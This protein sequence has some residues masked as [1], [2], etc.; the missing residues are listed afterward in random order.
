MKRLLLSVIV[1]LLMSN[2]YLFASYSFL[3]NKGQIRDKDGKIRSE[4]LFT[5]EANNYTIY[6]RK[7]GWSYVI[8]SYDSTGFEAVR[9][10]VELQNSK[11]SFK[12]ETKYRLPGY[13]NF[14]MSGSEFIS[15]VYSYQEVVYEGIYEGIDLRFYYDEG[16]LRYDYI[17]HPEADPKKI[18]ME[19]IHS[20]NP[21]LN[22]DMKLIIPTLLGD[23]NKEAPFTYQIIDNRKEEINSNYVL[24]GNI[25]SFETGDYDNSKELIIDP[26]TLVSA[27]LN[28]IKSL[29]RFDR[30][31]YDP[32]YYSFSL[33]YNNVKRL[34]DNSMFLVTN[35][36]RDS[37]FIEDAKFRTKKHIRHSARYT[38]FLPAVI[39]K[40]NPEGEKEWSTYIYE[41]YNFVISWDATDSIAAIYSQS[42]TYYDSTSFFYDREAVFV[43]MFDMKSGLLLN[44]FELEKPD[45][46]KQFKHT[47]MDGE[48][49]FNMVSDVNNNYNEFI[50]RNNQFE[51]NINKSY[52]KVLY[53]KDST[54]S[55]I[56][57]GQYQ[58]NN[59]TVYDYGLFLQKYNLSGELIYNHE[60]K[61]NKIYL[62]ANRRQV[63][64]SKSDFGC[65]SITMDYKTVCF[66]NDG[67][68][69]TMNQEIKNKEK[70]K[71]NQSFYDVYYNIYDSDGKLIFTS[72]QDN[73]FRFL[74]EKYGGRDSLR[75]GY[76]WYHPYTIYH[77]DSSKN[78]YLT[79]NLGKNDILWKKYKDRIKVNPYNP[80]PDKGQPC[81]MK[82]D[83]TGKLLWLSQFLKFP[84]N[85]TISNL[86][87]TSGSSYTRFNENG[88]LESYFD[89]FLREQIQ[90]PYLE[91]NDNIHHNTTVHFN[92]TMNTGTEL[93]MSLDSIGNIFIQ[94]FIDSME[95][96]SHP[97]SR[98]LVVTKM[99][100]D[101][102]VIWQ[103]TAA[104][105]IKY[106]NLHEK[107][108]KFQLFEIKSSRIFNHELY[109]DYFVSNVDE[110]TYM[111]DSSKYALDDFYPIE[112]YT[113]ILPDWNT[114]DPKLSTNALYDLIT[115]RFKL[116][117]SKL[118]SVTPTKIQISDTICVNHETLFKVEVSNEWHSQMEFEP[119][120]LTGEGYRIV[121]NE[122]FTLQAGEKKE[123]TIIFA[124][125]QHKTHTGSVVFKQNSISDFSHTVEFSGV[126]KAVI[127]ETDLVWDLG[128]ILINNTASGI[129]RIY[130]NGDVASWI[131]AIKDLPA[132]F[133][134]ISPEQTSNFIKG[135][136][137]LDYTIEFTPTVAGTFEYKYKIYAGTGCPD[138]LEV[139]IK[140]KGVTESIVINADSLDYGYLYFCENKT[141]TITIENVTNLP[142][143]Y[144]SSQIIGLNAD[145]FTILEKPND[146]EILIRGNPAKFVIEY[147]P[148]APYGNKSAILEI[149]TSEKTLNCPLKGEYAE[150]DISVN[151]IVM[152]IRNLNVLYD[153]VLTI[154]NNTRDNFTLNNIIIGDNRVT[155]AT[156]LPIE[157]PSMQEIE[158]ELELSS[159]ITGEINT[160]IEFIFS[161]RCSPDLTSNLVCKFDSSKAEI[162]GIDFGK[163]PWCEELIDSLRIYNTGNSPV[164]VTGFSF[165]ENDGSFEFVD[166]LT[167]PIELVSGKYI[168]VAVRYLPQDKVKSQNFAKVR[169]KLMID[170]SERNFDVEIIGERV[171]PELEYLTVIDF[172]KLKPGEIKNINF[173]I[174]NRSEE[175][176]IS[177][178]KTLTSN[179]SILSFTKAISKNEKGL[180][181]ISFSSEIIGEYADEMTVYFRLGDCE[182]SIK[183]ALKAD[184]SRLMTIWAN[185]HT[186]E[187]G[188]KGY[189][190]PIFADTDIGAQISGKKYKLNLRYLPELYYN[191]SSPD[192]QIL[193]KTPDGNYESMVIENTFPEITSTETVLFHLKGDVL[194]SPRMTTP[195][196]IEF[197]ESEA[198]LSITTRDGS[199]TLDSLCQVPIRGIQQFAPTR[200]SVSPN[201]SG[202]ELKVNIGTQED[203]SFRLVIFD[204][205]G[206]EVYRTEFTKS[207][208][209]FEQ[210]DY[211]INTQNLGNGIYT[212]HLTAPWTLLREQVVVVR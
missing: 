138:T 155:L 73:D 202:G 196:H 13:D 112:S 209:T 90:Y 203:G 70:F 39:Y 158:I 201:P 50:L 94:R 8:K 132:P 42:Y 2:S 36:V 51:W 114:I 156:A 124:P 83:S 183:I 106:D 182:D 62:V 149:I 186:S 141:D 56:A 29:Y 77:I 191:V 187:V 31:P 200:M 74:F 188:I 163:V 34:S 76:G 210:K 120:H 87:A 116:D 185:H 71:Q 102:D 194:F 171:I 59:D 11:V 148:L 110:M 198:S 159:S 157:I 146:G 172:G 98:R 55:L 173:E 35:D 67:S 199:L 144:N 189:E 101:G 207:D 97:T 84:D 45:G 93:I 41:K 26:V 79:K 135:G 103:D 164:Q 206:R 60:I 113:H 143:T 86:R 145:N 142:L 169:A 147:K 12:T 99:S 9:V 54:I 166:V 108:R 115:F 66:L 192:A 52:E 49:F 193:S 104:L 85:Y 96:R 127:I 46:I 10:D 150:I 205:Q 23:I 121:P 24:N 6:L 167:L 30:F 130:N 17:V 107:T 175:I 190:I 197:I 118:V 178:V 82:F 126:T 204:V 78:I 64:F 48:L 44:R 153:T 125:K 136:E 38:D 3:E 69:L 40:Y 151:D 161:G 180:I 140:G 174:L 72:E 100:P 33:N 95:Y 5:G 14:I 61:R 81:L 27:K 177:E 211:N 32:I 179:F 137:Y 154:R 53:L 4:V 195:I 22:D 131:Q 184:V 208:K 152:G 160:D 7:S 63:D 165:I 21:K 123:F 170:G 212:I 28:R 176:E 117:D 139:I 43:S 91:M 133:K 119:P 57:L 111:Q 19:I 80:N 20:D 75:E 134:Q 89:L 128:T 37:E 18:S 25:L 105:Y 65:S 109:L 181:N 168:A 129:F 47:Y 16:S 58:G 162:T 68:F 1:S 88:E 15:N 122:A 92:T